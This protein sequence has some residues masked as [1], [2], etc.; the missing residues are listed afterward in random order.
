MTSSDRSPA[1]LFFIWFS[2]SC[3]SRISLA[4]K[5]ESNFVFERM[6]SLNSIA[7]FWPILFS[8]FFE[9][10]IKIFSF[11]SSSL[12][13]KRIMLSNNRIWNSS[14]LSRIE[15]D[16]KRINCLSDRPWPMS[17]AN[18]LNS[19]QTI[20]TLSGLSCSSATTSPKY[21]FHTS[22]QYISSST[23]SKINVLSVLSKLI[24]FISLIFSS[25]P[26]RR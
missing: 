4:S 25:S 10:L 14:Q 6:K 16:F 13:I 21:F 18:L 23:N 22:L 7:R 11:V 12:I 17:K 3:P 15:N 5:N 9:W 1:A 20:C 8:S 19:T 26:V 2:K 24:D